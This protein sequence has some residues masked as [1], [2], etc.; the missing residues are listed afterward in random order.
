MPT[1]IE[2]RF[3]GNRKDYFLWP[4]EADPLHL[5]QPVIVESERGLDFGRATNR[6]RHWRIT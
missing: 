5:H 3:K 4:E 1:T 2:V 6:Q